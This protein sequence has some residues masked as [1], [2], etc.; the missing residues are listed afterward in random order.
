MSNLP[1]RRSFR[2]LK[3]KMVFLTPY[4][5]FCSFILMTWNAFK[6][7]RWMS[8]FSAW[9]H[10]QSC[11]TLCDPMD[12]SSPDSSVHGIFQTKILEW[13]AT[14]YWAHISCVSFIAGNSLPSEPS[15]KLPSLSIRK[16]YLLAQKGE[17]LLSW[18]RCF[19]NWF[20]DKIMIKNSK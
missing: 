20:W 6:W 11:S 10:A 19:L 12:Y 7:T 5:H 16:S 4:I 14:S 8:A 1:T 2:V 17:I 9:V 13:V 15:G 18:S 3:N